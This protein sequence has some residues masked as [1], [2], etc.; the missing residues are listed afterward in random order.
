M[1]CTYCV[2]FAENLLSHISYSMY[3]PFIVAS[4]GIQQLV[5]VIIKIKVFDEVMHCRV[6]TVLLFIFSFNNDVQVEVRQRFP[7]LGTR[8]ERMHPYI[9][10]R[11]YKPATVRPR[12][13]AHRRAPTVLS[14]SKTFT[15]DVVLLEPSQDSI[16]R[17]AARAALHD[18]AQ[19]VN[20]IDLMSSWDEDKV[21]VVLET[22]F[23]G[24]LDVTKPYP[25]YVHLW[26]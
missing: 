25:R 6:Q 2:D 18:K 14:I 8:G 20:M 22:C 10:R 9:P 17:G 24:I 12:S 26:L 19:I 13:S 7:T 3:I 11:T 1:W 23:D 15:R 16:P 4:G 21:R 5:A